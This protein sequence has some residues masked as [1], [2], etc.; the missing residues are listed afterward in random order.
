MG[1]C[2]TCKWWGREYNGEC[3]FVNTTYAQTENKRFEIVAVASDDQG[4]EAKLMT[5]ANFGCAFHEA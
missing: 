4:L 2:K 5:G 3:D 1:K